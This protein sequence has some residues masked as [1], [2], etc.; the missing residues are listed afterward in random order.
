MFAPISKARPEFFK[1]ILASFFHILRPF[2][3]MFLKKSSKPSASIVLSLT[4]ID[5]FLFQIEH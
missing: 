4:V 5:F 2:I 3:P 1:R